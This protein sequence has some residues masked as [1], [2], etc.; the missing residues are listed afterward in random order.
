M[1]KNNPVVDMQNNNQPDVDEEADMPPLLPLDGDD[2]D[3]LDAAPPAP[4][5]HVKS[6]AKRKARSDGN[7][8]TDR[9]VEARDRKL[10][11]E[12]KKRKEEKEAAEKKLAKEKKKRDKAEE[13]AEKAREK[14]AAMGEK[15][16]EEKKLRVAA[17]KKV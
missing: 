10:E 12:K 1:Q 5:A 15:L 4:A 14:T 6:G 8:R 13:Q 9:A 3:D 16:N 11:K 17:E 7:W 2:D